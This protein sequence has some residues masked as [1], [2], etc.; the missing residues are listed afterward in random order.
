MKVFLRARPMRRGR[1]EIR[2][3]RGNKSTHFERIY[4]RYEIELYLA[5]SRYVFRNSKVLR[6]LHAVI[7]HI[8]GGLLVAS[9]FEFTSC[10]LQRA[11]IREKKKK[12]RRK[13]I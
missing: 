2:T 7:T 13:T 10:D 8:I 1:G 12:K 9:V 6:I 5:I 11:K 3:R 4:I